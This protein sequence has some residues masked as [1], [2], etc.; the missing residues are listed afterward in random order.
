MSG[1][2]GPLL[3]KY[4][5]FYTGVK[6]PESA[7]ADWNTTNVQ[8]LTGTRTPT[9]TKILVVDCDGEEALERWKTICQ[10]HNHIPKTTW[11]ARTGGG[12]L[13]FYYRLG[14]GREC[15]S[16]MIWGVWDTWGDNGKGKWVKHKEVRIL[17]DNA[18]VVAPPSIHIETGQ[19]YRFED[20][21]NPNKIHL[22]ELAPDWLVS[23]PRLCAPR[24]GP[25]PSKPAPGRRERRG[26]D[27]GRYDR[28]DVLEAVGDAKLAIAK[29]W[30]L[31]CVSGA[32]A[33]GWVCCF[34]PGREDPRYSRPSGSF[35][36]NDGTLQDRKDCST[37]SFFDVGVALGRF[38]NWQD[39]R[40]HLGERFLKN[41]SRAIHTF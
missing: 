30:G 17:A 36:V 34:V 13:H 2:K 5:E 41:F 8:I 27:W 32:N 29:E 39:C 31:H 22:P 26:D 1:F 38:A 23:M 4:A 3:D 11:L 37:I 15:P 10:S 21:A 40:D 12:G 16:G 35:N 14:S 25:E 18:L 6:V 33:N 20:W 28:D 19:R 24:F 9:P 7:Y